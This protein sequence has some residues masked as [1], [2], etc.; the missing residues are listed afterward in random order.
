LTNYLHYFFQG[1]AVRFWRCGGI[2][3]Y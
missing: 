2:S 3:G 1:S